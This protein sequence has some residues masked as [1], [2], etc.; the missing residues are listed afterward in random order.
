MKPGQVRAEARCVHL[1]GWEAAESGD[2]RAARC[3][4][5]ADD[6]AEQVVDAGADRDVGLGHTVVRRDGRAQLGQRRIA[7]SVLSGGCG[8][9]C[10]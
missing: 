2:R 3:D 6:P 5:G 9:D 7:V 1:E 10:G 8:S 4:V